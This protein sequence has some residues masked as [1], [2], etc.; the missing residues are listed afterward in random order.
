MV[1]VYKIE[2]VEALK[3]ISRTLPDLVEAV[4]E[5]TQEVRLIR[6][7]L[8]AE[9]ADKDPWFVKIALPKSSTKEEE[10]EGEDR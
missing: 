4:R 9:R 3:L 10:P 6:K 8:E 1:E 7:V 5:L 2:Q